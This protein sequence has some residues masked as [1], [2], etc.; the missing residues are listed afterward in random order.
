MSDQDSAAKVGLSLPIALPVSEAERKAE[1]EGEVVGLYDEFRAP[2]F[3]YAASFGISAHDAEE[4]AQEVFLALFRHLCAGKSRRNL[5]AWIFRVAHNLALRQRA[6]VQSSARRNP[7][8]LETAERKPDGSPNPEES[9]SAEQRTER[10]SVVMRALP[11]VD[12]RCLRLRAEGLQYREIA[13]VTG[14]SLGAVAMS[15]ARSMERLMR[16][17]TR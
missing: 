7:G 11:E 8:T 4:V 6:A 12:Q 3:R 17:D 9:Y 5:R 13:R 10:L 16:A 1:L 15:L 2:I 14:M